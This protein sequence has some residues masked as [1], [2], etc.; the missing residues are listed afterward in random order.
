MTNKYLE[1]IAGI[2]LPSFK[3]HKERDL[4]D[5]A[6]LT[7][8]AAGLTMGA[9]R[10]MNAGETNYSSRKKTK[11]EEQSLVALQNINKTLKKISVDKA[12]GK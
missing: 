5:L 12:E 10:T 3:G 8:G 7:M 4:L 9:S 2:K 1:K 11:L 6:G